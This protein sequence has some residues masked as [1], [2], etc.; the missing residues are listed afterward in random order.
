MR[1]QRD[2][3]RARATWVKA[4][5]GPQERERREANDTFLAYRGAE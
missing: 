3:E 4:A 1:M 5:S 2:L